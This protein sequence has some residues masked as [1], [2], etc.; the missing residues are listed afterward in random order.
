MLALLS[1]LLEYLRICNK[2]NKES[3]MHKF[4]K[5]NKTA[6]LALPGVLNMTILLS[7]LTCVVTGILVLTHSALLQPHTAVTGHSGGDDGRGV[8]PMKAGTTH[9][10]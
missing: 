3:N 6:Q 1:Q 2:S 7:D 8:L 10:L 9:T 4:H 5:Y